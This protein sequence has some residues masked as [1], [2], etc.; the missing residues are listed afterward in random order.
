MTAPQ[1]VDDPL[2]GVPL[3]AVRR[4]K[5][6]ATQHLLGDTMGIPEGDWQL[7]STL[8][9]WTRAHVASH[10]SR[11]ADGMSRVIEGLA[12]GRPTRMYDSQ[13]Q[14]LSDIERGS[15][16]TGLELQIDLDTSTGRLNRAMDL[17]ASGAVSGDTELRAGLRLPVTLLPLARLHE[18][19][20]HHIDLAIGF[21]LEALDDEVA[22][23]LLA[24]VLHTIG[25]RADYPALRIEHSGGSARI[26]RAGPPRTVSGPDAGLYGWLI[27]RSDG[28]PLVGAVGPALPVYG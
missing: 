25:D 4:R 24:W 17:V 26:G 7:P 5:L 8:P 10:L 14:Q 1:Q 13:S 2:L 3:S 28:A 21:A 6:E 20:S 9:G 22:G 23:W 16:R 19:V 11:S 27:G 18:V 15:E 12:A